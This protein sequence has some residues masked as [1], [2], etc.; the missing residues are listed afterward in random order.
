MWNQGRNLADPAPVAR[1]VNTPRL[2][3]ICLFKLSAIGD[4]VHMVPVLRAIQDQRP[5]IALTWIIGRLEAK[6]VGDI[7]GVEFIVFDKRG[8]L[9]AVRELR[10]RLAGRR[11]DA[12]LLAQRSLRANLVSLAV[13]AR[14]R[15][16]FDRAR[17]SE[18]HGL[19]VNTRIAPMRGHQHVMDCLLSFLEPLGLEVPAKPRWDIPVS[20][21]DE[22]FAAEHVPDGQPTLI[23]SPASSHP[24]R[25]WRAERYAA[26]ADHAIERHGLRVLLCGGPSTI[27]RALGDA[28]LARMRHTPVDLIGRDTLKRFL[29]MA[30]RATLVLTPDSGPAHMANAVATPVLGLYAATDAERSGPYSSRALCV[31]RFP[32]AARSLLGREPATLRWGKHIH[33][34]GVMDLVSVE[35]VIARLDGFMASRMKQ[36]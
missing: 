22:A 19:A 6:L 18:L 26:V 8:G 17:Q 27:E 4:V 28:I 14:M 25:N 21:E 32:E 5:D 16:G 9:G 12:L 31:N 13:P 15:V 20:A 2:A 35:D 29:A 10:R 1:A 33:R 34:P 36:G 24:E 30:R 7:P 11:F 3:S 23:L